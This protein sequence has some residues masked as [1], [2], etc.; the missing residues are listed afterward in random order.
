MCQLQGEV[1]LIIQKF[2]A[3]SRWFVAW[4]Q[5]RHV[6][7]YI[8]H[9]QYTNSEISIGLLYVHPPLRLMTAT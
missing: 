1:V 2:I 7:Y 9:I 8:L 4:N 3:M 5:N 6:T